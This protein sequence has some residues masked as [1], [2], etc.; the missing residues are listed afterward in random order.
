MGNQTLHR[1]ADVRIGRGQRGFSIIELV[2]VVVIILV[3]TVLALP[4]INR[5]ITALR[6]RSAM[7]GVSGLLQKTRIEAVRTNRVQVLRLGNLKGASV[8][9]V[10]SAIAP[11]PPT[12]LKPL[13]QLPSGV[14]PE[15]VL[16][17]PTAFPSDQLLGYTQPV[18]VAPF[19]VVFNQR[20][21]PCTYIAATG[22]C[23]MTGYLYYF[24]LSSTLGDQWGAITVT[25]AGRI[26]VWTFNGADWV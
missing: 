20:G 22:V 12:A 2:I 8:V 1:R 16:V 19:E 23:T 6:M 24:R 17:P 26:R 5:S 11:G 13:V 18:S 10:D 7:G 21:L 14:A 25:P 3:V 4:S 15:T 9:Y